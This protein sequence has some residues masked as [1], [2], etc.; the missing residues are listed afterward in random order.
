VLQN[1]T[2]VLFILLKIL[3]IRIV[4]ERLSATIPRFNAVYFADSFGNIDVEV[5]VTSRET[6]SS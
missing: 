6:L 3:L 4:F 5:D 2:I 1:Y